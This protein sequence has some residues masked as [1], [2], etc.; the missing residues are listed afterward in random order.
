MFEEAIHERSSYYKVRVHR[1]LNTSS[2]PQ[3]SGSFQRPPRRE[4]MMCILSDSVHADGPNKGKEEMEKIS[5]MN[6]AS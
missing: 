3:D 2:V 1:P 4:D 6:E 5:P